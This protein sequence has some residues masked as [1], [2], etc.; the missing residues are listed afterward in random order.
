MKKDEFDNVN[1]DDS[2]FDG[3]DDFADNSSD[4]GGSDGFD[5]FDDQPAKGGSGNSLGEIWRNNPLIKFGAIGFGVVALII[6][7]R[8]FAGGPEAPKSS[9][10]T[11][12]KQGEAPGGKT[13]E[14]YR[15]AIDNVNEQRLEQ[16]L[17]QGTSSIPIPTAGTTTAVGQPIDETP[18]VVL[19]DPLANW[20]AAAQTPARTQDPQRL[21]ANTIGANTSYQPANAQQAEIPQAMGP[22][23]EAVGQLS[24]AMSQQMQSI[25][26]AH[27]IRAPRVMAVTAADYYTRDKQGEQ[28]GSGSGSN[29]E[30]VEEII[31]PAGTIVY[32][33]MLT[34]ANTDA[35]GPVLA[36]ISSGALNGNRILGTFANTESFITLDFNT[37]VIEGVS[38][39]I[40]AIAIDPKTTLPA[41]ATEVDRRYFTRFV[42]PAAASFIEGLGGAI[43]Q[44]ES[45]TVVVD[46]S[47][48]TSSTRKLNTRE[49]LAAGLEEGTRVIARDLQREADRVQPLI[50]VHAG[51]P[52]GI[53][54]LEPVVKPK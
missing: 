43:A 18:P 41:V 28:D 2:A 4:F 29:S 50:K 42:L 24:S 52:V 22:S 19:E 5:S 48:V 1:P 40:K 37:V 23:P 39:S 12:L 16:A 26:G 25:L 44:R 47:V 7:V 32:A 49:E 31:V 46:G 45:T 21:P 3:A 53:L 34:E 51:T 17:R 30:T 35:P 13:T 38:H 14:A 54:F 10:G 36:R 11:A 20:R 9:V 6:I 33:Q 15:D 8:A 27:E